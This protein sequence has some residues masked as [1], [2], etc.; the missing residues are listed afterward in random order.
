MLRAL[1]L[2]AVVTLGA[3]PLAAQQ[4]RRE[5][6]ERQIVERFVENYRAQAGLTPEQD[7]RFRTVAMRSFNQRRERVRRERQLWVALEGQ[8][9][10][11]VAANPDSVSRLLDGISA[12]RM[13]GVEQMRADDREYAAF[14]SPVQRAQL[15][16]Q[17]ER[18]QRNIEDM[19]RRRM[20]QG[21]GG[22]PPEQ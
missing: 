1:T 12:S 7:A 14:L 13:A 4:P 16:L 10:P 8:M 22:G 19:L 18:L 15:Y 21:M 17:V 5:A 6:L 20:Q 2:C 3:A 9:R 11:G